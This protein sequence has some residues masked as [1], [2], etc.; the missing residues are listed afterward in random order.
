MNLVRTQRGLIIGALILTPI[1]SIGEFANAV[2][3]GVLD[4]LSAE[5][6]IYI[7]GLKDIAFIGIILC[8]TLIAWRSKNIYGHSFLYLLLFVC[9]SGFIGSLYF[10]P[11]ILLGAGIRTLL[12]LFALLLMWRSVDHELQQ[13]IAKVLAGLLLVAFLLQVFELFYFPPFWGRGPFGL[14][15]R[16]PGFFLIPSTMGSF[17]CA[18]AYYGYCF[19]PRGKFRTFL[20]AAIA[21]AS[22]LLTASATA[23]LSLIF[24]YA[25][26]AYF[27]I[28]E[29]MLTVF[30]ATSV[31]LIGFF[32]LPEITSRPDIYQSL[33]DRISLVQDNVASSSLLASTMFGM[34]TNT[35]VSIV[36]TL[37]IPGPG[38][39]HQ[40]FISDSTFI[41]FMVNFGLLASFLY[42]LVLLSIFSYTIEYIGFLAVFGLFSITVIIVESF[43]LNL[44]LAVNVVYLSYLRTAR[45]E[46]TRALLTNFAP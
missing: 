20:L 6:P 11:L 14:N 40:A 21:P 9:A 45:I 10:M 3:G 46:I 17:T 1:L 42:L 5:T 35:G 34:A 15:L 31:I 41:S 26:V 44:L 27:R 33:L 4:Q 43:P 18:A 16:N 39:L 37:D 25:T 36:N 12:P 28:R 32:L 2:N 22:V 38:Y 24:L 7:K 29:R 19:L 8:G 30:V 23:L 13:Q